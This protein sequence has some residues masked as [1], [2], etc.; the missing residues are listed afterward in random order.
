[1]I[2]AL[3]QD[4]FAVLLPLVQIHLPLSRHLPP[5][6]SRPPLLTLLFFPFLPLFLLP[7]RHLPP[8]PQRPVVP[9][10]LPAEV[11]RLHVAELAEAGPHVV[12]ILGGVG[13]AVDHV[14]QGDLFV[15][16]HLAGGAEVGD[17][18][19]VGAAVAGLLVV[20]LLDP[21]LPAGWEAGVVLHPGVVFGFRLL[22]RCR[23]CLSVGRRSEVRIFGLFRTRRLGGFLGGW[24]DCCGRRL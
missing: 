11:G 14:V 1:M 15:V 8:P 3:Y 20:M 4:F 17:A 24:K 23:L 5:I 13:A 2:G 18:G 7:S 16:E 21:H 19:D 12:D 22:R 6:S 10:G 9:R